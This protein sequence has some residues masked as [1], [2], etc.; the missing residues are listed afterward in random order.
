MDPRDCKSHALNTRPRCHVSRFLRECVWEFKAHKTMCCK[1]IAVWC[2][3]H[4]MTLAF[5]HHVWVTESQLV[6]YVS[7][8][9][10]DCLMASFTLLDKFHFS[11]DGVSK[12]LASE[13][14]MCR[15]FSLKQKRKKLLQTR[16]SRTDGKRKLGRG[17]SNFNL[18]SL[19]RLRK[20]QLFNNYSSRPY[21]L[22]TQ[23][24]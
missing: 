6:T 4:H 7:R 9:Q 10:A 2:N 13:G 18:N 11:L 22:L 14:S 24:P 19:Y 21:G 3:N 23:R 17:T 8:S 20:L 5:K 16:H 15:W 12:C 1:N